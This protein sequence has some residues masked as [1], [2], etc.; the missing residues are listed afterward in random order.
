VNVAPGGRRADAPRFFARSRAVWR[1]W[2]RRHHDTSRE[3]WLV[4]CKKHTG[5]RSVVYPEA[6]DEAL[7]FG[8]ID[9]MVRSIDDERYMQRWTPR[10]NPR[11]WSDANLRHMRR[12]I[13]ERKMTPAGLRVLG[14]PL[15]RRPEEKPAAPKPPVSDVV[16]PALAAALR[17]DGNAAAVFASLAP[18][19]RRRYIAWIRDA[20]REETRARR[21]A[22]ALRALRAGTKGLLK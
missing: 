13:A 14:V 5:K 8:W 21:V 17:R 2:L 20:K 19:Y 6:L 10:R 15:D 16:P 7:C 18:S 12:L 22:E 11:Q 3:I 4:Y 9:G 1:A